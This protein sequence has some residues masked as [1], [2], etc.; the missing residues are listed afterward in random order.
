MESLNRKPT[1]YDVVVQNGETGET[2]SVETSNHWDPEKVESAE[3]ANAVAAEM[4]VS[5][6][7]PFAPISAQI[8][9]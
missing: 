6:R 9:S 2:V 3:V 8:R 5:E 7:Q 1:F 4:R